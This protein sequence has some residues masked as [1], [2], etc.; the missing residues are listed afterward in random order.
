MDVGDD[1]D[2]DEEE[3]ETVLQLRSKVAADAGCIGGQNLGVP[4]R[5]A[6]SYHAGL[7]TKPRSLVWRDGCRLLLVQSAPRVER[8]GPGAGWSKLA[9]VGRPGDKAERYRLYRLDRP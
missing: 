9:D 6:L 1:E 3:E 4:Q 2:D 5:A 8:D 7:R